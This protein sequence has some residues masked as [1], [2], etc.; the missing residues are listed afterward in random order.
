MWNRAGVGVAVAVLAGCTSM[1]RPEVDF[2]P[3]PTTPAPVTATPPAANGAIYQ[4]TAGSYRPL[5]EDRRARYVGDTL[6]I[7]INEKTQANTKQS[8]TAD[9]ASSLSAT[10]PAIKG[11]GKRGINGLDASTTSDTTFDGK[12]EAASDNLFTGTITV[13][14]VEVLTNGNLA[15]AGEKQIGIA[16]NLE[17]LKFTGIVNPTTI[18]S[19][20][21]VS[22]A[23]VADARIQTRG[24]GYIDQAQTMG[25]LSRFFMS[26]WPF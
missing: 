13:T 9:R 4:A 8:S 15:V 24:K 10:V 6:T 18:M 5:F 17:V 3:A 20:N 1:S 22:S 21:T 26:Y 11:I 12:G 16:Q 14:V 25:W 19:G 2:R 7:S 23:Q